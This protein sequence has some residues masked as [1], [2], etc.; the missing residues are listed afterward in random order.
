M[1]YVITEHNETITKKEAEM[2]NQKIIR[3]AT[4]SEIIEYLKEEEYWRMQGEEE[5]HSG[6]YHELRD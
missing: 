2:C 3:E 5:Q 1:E 6:S 4:E